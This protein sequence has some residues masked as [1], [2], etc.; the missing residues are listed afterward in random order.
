MT[1]TM[2]VGLVFVVILVVEW[3]YRLRVVRVGAAVLALLV[4]YFGQPGPHRAARR[5]V[6]MPLAERITQVPN[7]HPPLTD[8]Q[9]GVFTMERAVI[10]DANV[11]E[12]SR[13]LAIGVLAWLACSPAFESKRTLP[14]AESSVGLTSPINSGN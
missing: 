2:L 7:G 5:A 4:L 9:S 3:R 12:T 13:L 11:G 6:E 10:E 1:A 8:Y 14:V